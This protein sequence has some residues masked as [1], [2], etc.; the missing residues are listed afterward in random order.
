VKGQTSGIFPLTKY[1]WYEWLKFWDTDQSFPDS[2]EWLGRDLGPAIDVGP[3]M[4]PNVLN[5]NGEV[6]LRVSVR[7]PTLAEMK[8]LDEQKRR[9]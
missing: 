5:I 1:A 6:M 3:A 2:K 4:M 8:S 7:G 9:Q